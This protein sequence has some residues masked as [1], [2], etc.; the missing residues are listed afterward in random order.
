L[1]TSLFLLFLLY[2]LVIKIAVLADLANGNITIFLPHPCHYM[3]VITLSYH[4][5]MHYDNGMIVEGWKGGRVE[6][7]KGQES[8]SS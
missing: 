5:N 2:G 3:E 7:W 6:K 4:M 8:F 1:I